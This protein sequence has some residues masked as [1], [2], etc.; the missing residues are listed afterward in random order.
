MVLRT[1]NMQT[2]IV[3]KKADTVFF[4]IGFSCFLKSFFVFHNPLFHTRVIADTQ[5]IV[6]RDVIKCR[7]LDENVR[8]D[9]ALPQFIVAVNLLRAVKD[10][11]Y[12]PL[13]QIAILA[14]ISDPSVH[15]TPLAFKNI[16]Q[17]RK[18]QY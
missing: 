17:N 2:L 13:R 1:Q 10:L 18:L 7:K 12:F 15:T 14:Q 8:G 4:R 5:N 3:A 9:I 6:N 11:G 16:I